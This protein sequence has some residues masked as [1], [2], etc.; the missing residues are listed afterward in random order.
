MIKSQIV[1]L[2]AIALE[3]SF[4]PSCEALKPSMEHEKTLLKI[5]KL[6]GVPI[7]VTREP[8]GQDLSQ[9]VL[10]KVDKADR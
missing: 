8:S 5:E 3:L 10:P 4:L 2:S 6:T 9:M 7:V 1:K